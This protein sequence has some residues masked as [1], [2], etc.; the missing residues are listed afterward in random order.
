MVVLFFLRCLFFQ[1]FEAVMNDK[2]PESGVQQEQMAEDIENFF[3]V[4]YSVSRN[5]SFN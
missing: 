4:Q 2:R 1:V 3:K 5:L